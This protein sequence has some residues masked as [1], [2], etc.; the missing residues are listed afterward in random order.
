[1]P[2]KKYEFFLAD[3]SLFMDVRAFLKGTIHIR[4][5]QDF[6]KRLNIEAGRLNGWVKSPAEAE[7]EMGVANAGEYFGA[8]FKLK[9][10]PLLEAS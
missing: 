7:A 1:E 5:D 2:G 8:N 6:M 9:A 10:I 3:D 4:V